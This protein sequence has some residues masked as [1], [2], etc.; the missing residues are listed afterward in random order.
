MNSPG[1]SWLDLGSGSMSMAFT[2]SG[3]REVREDRHSC[4]SFNSNQ[5]SSRIS[6]RS[7]WLI[8]H[9]GLR[10]KSIPSGTTL[11]HTWSI[12]HS[13]IIFASVKLIKMLASSGFCWNLHFIPGLHC[14][15][16]TFSHFL[17]SKFL[18]LEESCLLS[19]AVVVF[20]I[21]LAVM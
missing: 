15:L 11:P 17:L 8:Q 7:P 13:T 20:N 16:A 18:I 21:L 3:L 9:S 1:C 12:V 10:Q 5:I 4:G 6:L 19:K 14:S 2:L